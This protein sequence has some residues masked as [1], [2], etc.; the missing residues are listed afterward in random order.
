MSTH[1][2]GSV[3]HFDH[4]VNDWNIFQNQMEQFFIANSIA[5]AIKKKA[6]FLTSISE[7][8][9]VLL[10]NLIN[11]LKAESAATTFDICVNAMQNHFK[12]LASG[13]AERYKFYNASKN[14]EES[15][16]EWAVRVRSLAINCEFGGFLDIA[17]RDK[18]VM[19]LEKGTAR[20]KI[21]LRRL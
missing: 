12:P 1:I 19:G 6:I 5:D 3:P 13:F 15:V 2:I 8:S 16:N 7:K 14:S 4:E 18:F 11:P 9:Y 17:I 21:F 10:Q 20:D